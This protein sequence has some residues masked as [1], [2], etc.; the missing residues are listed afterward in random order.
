MKGAECQGSA[1]GTD[2]SL[3]AERAANVMRAIIAA[4]NAAL[5][6]L[7]EAPRAADWPPPGPSGWG[8]TGPP[9]DVGLL[10][11]PLAGPDPDEGG[12]PSDELRVVKAVPPDGCPAAPEER[13][14]VRTGSAPPV[15]A[16]P[17][18]PALS[19]GAGAS[20]ESGWAEAG[21]SGLSMVT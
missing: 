20:P 13:S 2:L 4:M 18:V 21:G 3:G 15:R 8:G 10:E 5:N 19:G 11:P 9:G 12:S 16:G 14:S 17:V 7:E 1:G 6:A